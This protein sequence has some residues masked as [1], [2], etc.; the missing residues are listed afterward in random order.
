MTTFRAIA[1][2]S[3]LLAATTA[4]A[5]IKVVP[6]RGRENNPSWVAPGYNGSVV[7]VE[8]RPLDDAWLNSMAHSRARDRQDQLDE[9]AD[10]LEEMSDGNDDD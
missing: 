7:I 4:T 9:M 6:G 2:A 3:L 10:D 8:P 1:A 5:Q